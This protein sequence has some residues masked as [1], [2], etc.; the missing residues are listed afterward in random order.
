MRQ[1]DRFVP[2][3]EVG[4]E[5]KYSII[6]DSPPPYRQSLQIDVET[7]FNLL[8][9]AGAGKGQTRLGFEHQQNVIRATPSLTGMLTAATKDTQ[10]KEE[11]I[12]RRK[13]VAYDTGREELSLN[14]IYRDNEVKTPKVTAMNLSR[15][16]SGAVSI[17]P[18]TIY[19]TNVSEDSSVNPIVDRA[20]EMSHHIARLGLNA[21]F[22]PIIYSILEATTGASH[23]WETLGII[24]F[25]NLVLIAKDLN[26]ASNLLTGKTISKEEEHTAQCIADNPLRSLYPASL[27]NECLLPTAKIVAYNSVTPAQLL[28]ANEK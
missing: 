28:K 25:C 22:A 12:Q 23:P 21:T 9:M 13:P 18:A 14:I 6:L 16:L 20:A 8:K 4:K 26:L 17:I 2:I 10:Y 7:L 11:K 3:G 5:T 19:S 24:F 27:V 1:E 15:R